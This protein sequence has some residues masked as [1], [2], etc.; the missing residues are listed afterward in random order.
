M[1]TRGKRPNIGMITRAL[2]EKIGIITRTLAKIAQNI[3]MITR[4]NRYYHSRQGPNIGMIT[5]GIGYNHSRFGKNRPNVGMITRDTNLQLLDF[6]TFLCEN[7]ALSLFLSLFIPLKTSS[8]WITQIL[9]LYFSAYRFL[10][11]PARLLS[12]EPESHVT[13]Q[14]ATLD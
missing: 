1:I 14:P 10:L 8:L 3:G 2:P 12:R 5:R 11:P 9:N 4:G 13:N 7:S 6:T